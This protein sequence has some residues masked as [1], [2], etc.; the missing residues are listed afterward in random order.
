MSTAGVVI[1][2]YYLFLGNI[3]FTYVSGELDWNQKTDALFLL[4]E[5]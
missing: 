3:S 1:S 5:S 4:L 2:G